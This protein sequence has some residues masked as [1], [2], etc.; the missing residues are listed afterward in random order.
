MGSLTHTAARCLTELK[1]LG[2]LKGQLSALCRG[3]QIRGTVLL[4]P[5]GIDLQI[6]G[7]PQISQIVLAALRS[8]PALGALEASQRQLRYQ[9]YPRLTVRIVGTL[10]SATDRPDPTLPL[11]LP[12]SDAGGEN[13]RCTPSMTERIAQRHIALQKAATPLPGRRPRDCFKPINVPGAC[14]GISLIEAL[15]HLVSHI[16]ASTWE[17]ECLRGLITTESGESVTTHRVVRAGQ[18]Y[19]HR[20]PGRVEPDVDARAEILHEDEAL[21]V[22]NKPAPLPMHA[23]GRFFRNTLQEFLNAAYAPIKPKPVH[24]LDA[25]TTGLVLVALHPVMVGRL[26]SQ[27]ISGQVEKRYLVRVQGHPERDSFVCEAPIS[28]SSGP[29]GS[30]DVDFEFGLPASTGFQVIHR[31]TDG[32][33][34]LEARPFTGRTNQIRV[35]LWS[36]G[37]PVYGD[38][39]YLPNG[40]RG[41]TQTLGITDPPLCLHAWKLRFTHPVNEIPASFCAPP[42]PWASLDISTSSCL[43]TDH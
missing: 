30:R 2:P 20:F 3:A 23:G 27:F 10:P 37:L 9:P 15:C 21:A 32:T 24:R 11:Q 22:V 35:H 34:L 42:P 4:A 33:A 16:P 38:A 5:N 31:S 36:L 43:S 17:A 7:E 1:D 39:A 18:R 6:A 29:L 19:L 13:T 8:S 28:R 26:Q 41:E 40:R 25:N 14:D 12:A